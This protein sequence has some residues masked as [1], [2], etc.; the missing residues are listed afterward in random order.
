MCMFASNSYI[1][2]LLGQTSL[3][4]AS[5]VTNGLGFELSDLNYL[6]SNTSLASKGLYKPKWKDNTN[7]DPL[8]SGSATRT[9]DKNWP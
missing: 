8:I 7:L 1:V 4:T 3:Q 9:A 2:D 5:E 6:P